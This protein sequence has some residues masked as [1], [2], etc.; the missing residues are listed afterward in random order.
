MSR[1]A[2]RSPFAVRGYR[3]QWSADL[4][5]S[6]AFEMETVI[7]GWYIA[8]ETQSVLLV[9]LF[10]ALQFIGTLISP[11]IG[12]AGDA[13][14]YRAVLCAMRAVYAVVAGVLALLALTGWLTPTLAL[15]AAGIA[16]LLRASDTGIRNVLISETLPEDRLMSGISLSRITADSARV[17]GALAGAGVVALLGMGQAYLAVVVFYLLGAALTLGVGG[18]RPMPGAMATLAT[19]LRGLWEAARSVWHAPPQ[20]AAMLV[21]LLVNLMAF[22]FTLGLLPYVAQEVYGTSQTGLGLMM[23]TVGVGSILASLLLSRMGPTVRPARMMLGFSV[24]WHALLIVFGQTGGL[25]PGLPLLLAIGAAQILCTLPMSVLLLRGAPPELRGRVMG[26]R[27]L[28]VYGLPVGLLCAAPLIE[29]FGFAATATLYGG[30]G[31]ALT[32]LVLLRWRRH[33]WPQNVPGNRG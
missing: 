30:T 22:P 19:P 7:L 25:A 23:A 4:M 17:A 2:G 13:M 5:T 16:G 29:R 9:T 27:T 12:L 3:F 24:A 14:G 33:L 20:L 8:V 21:A 32:L 31:I 15:V 11:F 26:I 10:G 28:A 1:P 6:W 18:R